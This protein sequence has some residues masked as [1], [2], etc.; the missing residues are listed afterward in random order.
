MW[1][2]KQDMKVYE[3]TLDK[4]LS[5]IVKI[6]KKQFGIQPVTGKVWSK[7]ERTFPCLC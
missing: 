2:N 3:K 1:T 6:D 7:E 4:R 5:D